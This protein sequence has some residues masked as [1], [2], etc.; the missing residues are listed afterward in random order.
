MSYGMSQTDS[1]ELTASSHFKEEINKHNY[2]VI[3]Y[4]KVTLSED[5]KEL[6]KK[7]TYNYS[8][9]ITTLQPYDWGTGLIDIQVPNTVY[10]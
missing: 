8:E 5:T 4:Y 6:V 2:K 9:S 1:L 3:T 7:L 10:L